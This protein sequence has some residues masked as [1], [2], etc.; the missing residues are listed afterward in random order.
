MGRSYYRSVMKQGAEFPYRAHG[1]VAHRRRE[2]AMRVQMC[3][4]ARL[5]RVGLHHLA[6]F[7][8]ASNAFHCI[9]KD[10]A[11]GAADDLARPNRVD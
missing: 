1:G 10:R 6:Q 4:S 9:H 11:E 2:D 8:D 3:G 7:H 5:C